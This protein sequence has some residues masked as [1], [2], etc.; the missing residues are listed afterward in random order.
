MKT[1]IIPPSQA[2]VLPAATPAPAPAKKRWF[3]PAQTLILLA[4]L[5]VVSVGPAFNLYRAGKISHNAILIY[6]PLLSQHSPAFEFSRW[7]L[8]QWLE[9]QSSGADEIGS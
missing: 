5:Y 3:R 4:I 9:A 6:R 8:L 2:P 1:E 7:Y